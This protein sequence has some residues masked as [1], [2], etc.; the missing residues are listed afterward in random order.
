[1]ALPGLPADIPKISICCC[2]P[3]PAE[4]GRQAAL[5]ALT[6][7]GQETLGEA[8]GWRDCISYRFTH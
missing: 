3:A 8:G 1:M 6:V 7:D 4:M 2:S 5:S